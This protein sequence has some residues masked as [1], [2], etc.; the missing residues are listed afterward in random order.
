M[1]GVYAHANPY[2]GKHNHVR[3]RKGLAEVNDR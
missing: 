3:F 2:E 1:N